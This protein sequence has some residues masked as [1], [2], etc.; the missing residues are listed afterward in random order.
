MQNKHRSTD[1]LQANMTD[2]P[3]ADKN[4]PLEITVV[5]FGY[6]EGPPP[7]AGM[8]FDVRFL[9]NP[10]WVEELR[11]M[12]GLDKPVSDFVLEQVLAADFLDSLLD[13]FKRTLPQ[14]SQLDVAELT[15]A[16]GCTGGQHRSVALT[17]ALAAR[18]KEAF[19]QYTVKSA[20]REL[21]AK[22]P[23]LT[24]VEGQE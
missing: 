21:S 1:E 11:P 10:Y 20:H 6:K 13:L 22:Q 15:V 24:A 14:F 9:K 7:V 19:P 2:K 4:A 8:V 3:R 23:Q 12:T 18:L 16:F 17:E 5:S